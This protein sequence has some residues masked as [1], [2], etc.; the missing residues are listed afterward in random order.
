MPPMGVL[1]GGGGALPDS[2][3]E[4]GIRL[5]G[6]LRR[7]LRKP[8]SLGPSGRRWGGMGGAFSSRR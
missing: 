4:Y 3:A 8:A 5:V 7:A 1:A 2:V 6:R